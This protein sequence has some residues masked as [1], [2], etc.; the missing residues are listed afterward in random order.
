MPA[1]K[2]VEKRI[3]SCYCFSVGDVAEW[4]KRQLLAFYSGRP[5]VAGGAADV[6]LSADKADKANRLQ[7]GSPVGILHIVE[8]WQSGRM[9]L[10]A[11]E[12]GEQSSRRFESSR[13]R[14]YK[15]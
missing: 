11:K 4:S 13:L 10:R 7:V 12:L 6:S 2:G 14:F 9:R 15:K 1:W 5:P 8:T 3:S